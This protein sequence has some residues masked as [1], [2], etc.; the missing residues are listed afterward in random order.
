M[1]DVIL[2][3][4]RFICLPIIIFF[5]HAYNAF[6]S[7]ISVLLLVALNCCRPETIMLLLSFIHKQFVS[8]A[9]VIVFF[10]PLMMTEALM[11][12]QK[13]RPVKNF[14]LNGEQKQPRKG[15]NR[16]EPKKVH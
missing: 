2:S 12:F 16:T 4:R 6:Y 5:L 14:K 8:A 9:D 11:P 15:R 13:K 3:V 1:S 7:R 10:V